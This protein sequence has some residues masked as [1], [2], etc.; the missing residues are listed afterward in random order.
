MRDDIDIEE[1]LRRFESDPGPEVKR[2]ILTRFSQKFGSRRSVEHKTGFWR[3][4]VPL[5]VTAAGIV[6]AVGL[7]FIVG[8]RSAAPQQPQE[9][10]REPAPALNAGSAAEIKWEVAPNDLL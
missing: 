9:M 2:S 10:L 4:P 8:Q 7:S 5:Y 6:V 1:T 3:T